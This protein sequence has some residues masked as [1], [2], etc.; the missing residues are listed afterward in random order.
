MALPLVGSRSYSVIDFSKTCEISGVAGISLAYAFRNK[1]APCIILKS[2]FA[3]YAFEFL[4][5]KFGLVEPC[6]DVAL[7]WSSDP[8]LYPQAKVYRTQLA[9]DFNTSVRV[10]SNLKDTFARINESNG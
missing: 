6:G 2:E 7:V 1:S 3:K 10:L 5:Y 4:S 8:W 9:E